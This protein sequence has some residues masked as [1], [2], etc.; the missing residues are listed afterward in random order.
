M[1]VTEQNEVKISLDSSSLDIMQEKADKLL[2][3]LQNI[4]ALAQKLKN[5]F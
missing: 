3:T 5:L 2:E 1:I 4:Y